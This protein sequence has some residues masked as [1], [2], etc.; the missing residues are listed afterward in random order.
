M[1]GENRRLTHSLWN[2]LLS[3]QR[4]VRR[5]GKFEA[6][7]HTRALAMDER[8]LERERADLLGR[9]AFRDAEHR[10]R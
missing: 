3:L 2:C 6:D 9:I 4:S 10:Y 8:K 7:Y 5:S 1:G